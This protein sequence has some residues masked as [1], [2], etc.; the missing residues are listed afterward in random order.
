MAS[1]LLDKYSKALKDSL[2][3]VSQL[4]IN[5]YLGMLAKSKNETP[6][7]KT[8]TPFRAGA[9]KVAADKYIK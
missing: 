5:N 3:K 1:N 4:S 7:S 9:A 6:L 8:I 2:Q